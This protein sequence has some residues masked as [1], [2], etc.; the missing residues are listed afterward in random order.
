MSSDRSAS[1][2]NARTGRVIA[3]RVRFARR[4]GERLIGLLR[5]PVLGDDEALWLEPCNGIH[6]VGLRYPIALIVCNADRRVLRVWRRVPPCRVVMPIRHGRISIE[7]SPRA[8]DAGDVR[9]GDLLELRD[10]GAE[11][12]ERP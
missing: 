11:R 8:L 12:P 5:Q 2:V 10:S 3:R 7:T 4:L 6:T 9:E 1:L